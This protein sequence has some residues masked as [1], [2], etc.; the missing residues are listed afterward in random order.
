MSEFDRDRTVVR[1][2]D[3][4]R[5]ADSRNPLEIRRAWHAAAL[6]AGWACPRDWWV[7]EVDGVTEALVSGADAAAA[8][9]RLA[10]A[11]AEGGV[12][13]R[14]GL[15]D[16]FALY[17]TLPPA[18]PP[19]PL[20]R[21]FAECWADAAVVPVQSLTCEDPLTGLVSPAYLRTRLAE[22]YREAERSGLPVTVHHALLVVLA[23]PPGSTV[24]DQE[25][26]PSG[27]RGRESAGTEGPGPDS[28]TRTGELA[29]AEPDPPL[30]GGWQS[31]SQLG[32]DRLLHRLALG[33]CLRGAFS[34]SETFAAM[35]PAVSVGL[36][37]R[38]DA[39]SGRVSALGLRLTE[40]ADTVER[41]RV[42]IEQL[43]KEI[44]SAYELLADLAR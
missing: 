36:V 22:V 25:I 44:S 43:P 8:I 28:G 3:G 5:G 2:R 35:S 33:E 27:T 41:P 42:W 17:R 37:V 14:E 26:A 7:P 19:L 13:L 40:V 12:G 15:D 31:G 21:A 24:R 16:L 4:A 20:V 18:A 9:G 6:A 29:A 34:G 38:D 30:G 10:E 23:A 32:W 1:L 11:R 39:L